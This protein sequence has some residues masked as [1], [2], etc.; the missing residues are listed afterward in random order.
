MPKV[1]K[2]RLFKQKNLTF[3]KAGIALF[4][5]VF[6]FQERRKEEKRQKEREKTGKEAEKRQKSTLVD[7]ICHFYAMLCI[8]ENALSTGKS[9]YNA[10]SV[11]L[12]R[13]KVSTCVDSY[14]G[15]HKQRCA[16]AKS[17]S[18]CS[19]P[20][21]DNLPPPGVRSTTSRQSSGRGFSCCE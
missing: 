21:Q 11:N 19:S 20:V 12:C 15:D 13:Q 4:T 2:C 1:Y 10:K 9:R 6:R 8:P 5:V 17:C 18:A 14:R 16:V 3:F 7:M